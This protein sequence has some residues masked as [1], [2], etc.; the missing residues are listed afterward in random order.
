MKLNLDALL[1]YIHLHKDEIYCVYVGIEGRW[2]ETSDEVYFHE[3]GWIDD[4][5]AC[6][7]SESGSPAAFIHYRNC[8][9]EVFRE[10]I[11]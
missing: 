7:E 3:C 2:P 10:V 1:K 9:I 6:F 5:N 11:P 4:H 8:D